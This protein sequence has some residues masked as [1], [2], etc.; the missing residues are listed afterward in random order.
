MS[1]VAPMFGTDEI[2][3]YDNGK[4]GSPQPANSSGWLLTTSCTIGFVRRSNRRCVSNEGFW[5]SSSAETP[6]PAAS[7]CS[8][9][10]CGLFL[11]YRTALT[12]RSF[13][14]V[15]S[16]NCCRVMP[17][18]AMSRRTFEAKSN[19]ALAGDQPRPRNDQKEA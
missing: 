7:R 14:P 2:L 1:S 11:P 8:V 19:I 17:P 6:K 15:A 5:K 9:R 18:R 12:V 3:W 13:R 10:A 4:S 16:T